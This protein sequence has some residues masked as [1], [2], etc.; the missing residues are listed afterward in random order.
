MPQKRVTSGEMVVE[1]STGANVIESSVVLGQVLM[2]AGVP[3]RLEER[4]MALTS[5][6]AS[7]MV[8]EEREAEA[9]AD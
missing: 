3:E 9:P 1:G 5:W 7:S 8:V 4:G 6:T 2:E